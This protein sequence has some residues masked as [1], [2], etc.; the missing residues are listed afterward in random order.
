MYDFF[1]EIFVRFNSTENTLLIDDV[2]CLEEIQK[3]I[4]LL[5]IDKYI[6]PNAARM[7]FSTLS[8]DS[9]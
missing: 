3:H 4:G 2:F 9:I 8:T 5:H 7:G 1:S 6:S